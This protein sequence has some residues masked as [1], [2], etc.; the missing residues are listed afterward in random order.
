MLELVFAIFAY[1]CLNSYPAFIGWFETSTYF[2]FNHKL[3]YSFKEGFSLW[4]TE[5]MFNSFCFVYLSS[6]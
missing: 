6:H 1:R 4:K 3:R 2:D 5:T